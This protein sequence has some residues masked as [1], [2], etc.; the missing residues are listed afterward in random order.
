MNNFLLSSR[1]LSAVTVSQPKISTRATG[2][3]EKTITLSI[4]GFLIAL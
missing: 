2:V 4:I 3:T 1:V